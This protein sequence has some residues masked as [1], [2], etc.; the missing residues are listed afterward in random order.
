MMVFGRI[1]LSMVFILCCVTSQAAINQSDAPPPISTTIIDLIQKQNHPFLLATPERFLQGDRNFRDGDNLNLRK[2]YE[3]RILG[4]INEESPWY[5]GR[6]PLQEN[7]NFHP[8]QMVEA[9]LYYYAQVVS[10]F[11][12]YIG[13]SNQRWAINR[14]KREV[15]RLLDEILPTEE[16]A[17]FARQMEMLSRKEAY[18]L[19]LTTLLYDSVY[20]RFDTVARHDPN[21]RIKMLR[22]RLALFC[23]QV[24]EMPPKDK[25]IYGTSLG[26]S[27]LFCISVYPYEW[28]NQS[29][30]TPQSLLPD[31]YRAVMLTHEGIYELV[32]EQNQ[33]RLPLNQ[34]QGYLHLMIPW[35]ECMRSLK[36]PFSG[37]SG[38]YAVLV[39]AIEAHRSPGSARVVK[40]YF[41]D[42]L[43]IPWLP[44]TE[45]LF[46]ELEEKFVHKE[47]EKKVEEE[48]E[49][50]KQS[51]IEEEDTSNE[52]IEEQQR[53]E[54]LE[55][56]REAARRGEMD[57][58]SLTLREQLEFHS[59]PQ[60]PTPTP[61]PVLK[62]HK[63]R[64]KAGWMKPEEV[65]LPT[66]WGALYLLAGKE[67]PTLGVKR[68][69]NNFAKKHDSHPYTFLYKPKRIQDGARRVH[70]KNLFHYPE[71]DFS[72]L[73]SQKGKNRFLMAAQAAENT[74]I[75]STYAIHHD[76]Y[77]MND[78]ENR[79]RWFH[80]WPEEVN[81]ATKEIQSTPLFAQEAAEQVVSSTPMLTPMHSCWTT[82]SPRGKTYA[83]HRHFGGLG[84]AYTVIAHFPGENEDNLENVVFSIPRKYD[85]AIS[86]DVPGFIK[87][88]PPEEDNAFMGGVSLEEWQM[89]RVMQAG[90]PSPSSSPQHKLRIILSPDSFDKVSISEGVLGKILDLRRKNLDEPFFYLVA[91]EERGREPFGLKYAT[92]PIPRVKVLEWR[93]GVEIIGINDEEELK[94][95]FLHTDA[96][97][98]AVAEDKTSDRIFYMM[99]NG[100][101]LRVKFSPN[102][103]DYTMLV[104]TKG[105]KMNAAWDGRR[106][107]TSASPP[108]M[109]VF[110]APNAFGF[111]CS[112]TVVE[113]GRKGR[114]VI[115]WG[116]EEKRNLRFGS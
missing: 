28:K 35:V 62:S 112:E 20:N 53:P 33:L 105:K 3:K 21:N 98:V 87:I 64:K 7:P 102:Q 108:S 93:H 80:E 15:T 110:F 104:D 45:L 86:Q 59:I 14:M 61:T 17:N 11:G 39:S 71:N 47:K 49:E 65:V 27:T 97:L 40:P 56:L 43:D 36:Y 101:Y 41:E 1:F 63:E 72:M 81:K 67:D 111:E 66:I 42:P 96:E 89:M 22:D 25:L 99:M 2:T 60:P 57:R 77:Y 116:K 5:V 30:F 6:G 51:R 50:K 46:K 68:I 10:E 84:S 16:Q 58:R 44:R 23:R 26:L 73:S 107:F 31:L 103:R 24:D 85:G 12:A 55:D 90:K 74:I 114:Q 94:N 32:S 38:L 52:D 106:V 13:F 18:L 29:R 82:F 92:I 83:F 79:W 113:Y 75:T 4:Y 54:T 48:Q 78:N 69:W 37:N 109:S 19:G 9:D 70:Y 34:L 91:P 76:S 88:T 100:S 115:V 95:A 8:G